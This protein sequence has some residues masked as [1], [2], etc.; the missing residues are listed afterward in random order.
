MEDAPHTGGVRPGRRTEPPGGSRG[1]RRALRLLLLL[2]PRDFRE[3]Y[4]EEWIEAALDR[5]ARVRREDHRW[6]RAALIGFLLRDV[7]LSLALLLRRSS[8]PGP[9]GAGDGLP[10]TRGPSGGPIPPQTL[11]PRISMFQR[12]ESVL[13]DIRFSLRTLRRRPLFTFIALGTLGLG[14]G[15][16]T[17]IFSVVEGV[18]LRPLPY[19]RPGELV[20]VWETF[21]GWR[22]N[23]QLAAGWDQMYLAWPDYER[24]R[25][26]QTMFQEVA[27]YGGTTKIFS[28]AG[29]AEEISVGM[30]SA[31]LLSALG[32]RPVLGRGFLPGEDGNGADRIA[33]L[34]HS[35]WQERFGREPG[36]LNES[37]TL[38][39]EPYAIVGVLPPA[40]RIRSLGFFG[41]AGN[42]PVWIPIGSDGGSLGV[43]SHSFEGVARLKPGVTLVQASA[44]TE[45]L[46]R[47]DRPPEE[48]SARLAYRNEAELAGLREPLYLLLGASLVLLLIACGN[49]ATLLMGE[50]TGRRHELATRMAVGAGRRRL[51]RQLVT[52]SVLLGIAGSGLGILLSVA[53]TGA[54]VGL[55]PPLPRLGQVGVNG[56]VLV[57]AV[58]VGVVTGIIFGLAPSLDVFR[59]PVRNA[60]QGGT[61]G[62]ERQGAVFQR[63][64]VSLEV[65]LTVVLLVSGGL[66]VRSLNGLFAVEPGFR[67]EGLVEVR[68]RLPGYRYSERTERLFAFRQMQE[69]IQAVPGVEAVSGTTRPPFSVSPNLLS[70]GIEGHDVPQGAISPHTSQYAVLPGYFEV[71]GIPLL[72]GRSLSETDGE[73]GPAVAV[74]SESMARRF[75]RGASPLGTRIYFGDT[76][77]IVGIVGDVRHEAMDAEVLPSLYLPLRLDPE[78]RFSF[79]IRTADNP[80]SLLPGLREAVASVDSD[81]PV[82]R[83]ASIHSLMVGSARGERFRTVLMMVFGICA[84]LLAGAGV[85]GVTSRGVARRNREMGIRMALGARGSRL[86]RMVLGGSLAAGAV[87]IG[88]GLVGA[89]GATRLLAQ[90]LFGIDSWDPLTYGTAACAMVILSGVASYVPARRASRVAPMAVLREE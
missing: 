67:Q 73:G 12:L 4:G 90:Y 56:T 30:G 82:L 74:I 85:F 53:G 50:I 77:T 60:F 16:T 9:A 51:L 78:T 21:P 64:V 70:F 81:V 7:A 23:P 52:E 76:L 19:Q 57:F 59:G 1:T 3:D 24:W 18:L 2:Y 5:V 58:S 54:L 80:E 65:A 34:S 20:Q 22:D 88:L 69:A 32:I 11:E 49:V 79:V 75:W 48:I 26:G 25:D 86:V 87:G 15:A 44:E 36:V 6:P 42:S 17:A 37:I 55:A 33:L 68:V 31:S 61:R 84:A 89:L 14:I 72:A 62:Q 40:F 45:S 29:A 41:G 71:M 47:G 46:L 63:G 13:Q 35:F 28:G 38:N 66:L 43:N 83:T 39:N 27:L 10:A 8:R